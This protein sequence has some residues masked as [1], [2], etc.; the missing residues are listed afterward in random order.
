MSM[1]EQRA[2]WIAKHPKATIEEAWTAGYFQSNQNWCKGKVG[3][4]EECRKLL[5]QLIE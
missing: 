4:M 5:K 3:L 2:E 1:N